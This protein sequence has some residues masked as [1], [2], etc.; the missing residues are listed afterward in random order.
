MHPDNDR[1]QSTAQHQSFLTSDLLA[2]DF[3]SMRD[4][5]EKTVP[6]GAMADVRMDDAIRSEGQHLS[7]AIQNQ[8]PVD[9]M[10]TSLPSTSIDYETVLPSPTMPSFPTRSRSN[11]RSYSESTTSPGSKRSS[12]YFADSSNED[13][14]CNSNDAKRRR[15]DSRNAQE[16]LNPQP[17]P[18]AAR[19]AE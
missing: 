10:D 6:E 3:T 1:T 17:S 19:E 16:S 7:I 2:D 13:D 15:R 12:A 9:P 14:L 18:V 11:S 4:M 8:P 5:E